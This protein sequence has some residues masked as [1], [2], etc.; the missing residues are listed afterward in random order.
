MRLL[1]SIPYL[2]PMAP[3]SHG[4]RNSPLRAGMNRRANP[5]VPQR[6][7]E[8]LSDWDE[9]V[10]GAPSTQGY[11]SRVLYMKP[12]EKVAAILT[13]SRQHYDINPLSY[14]SLCLAR[15]KRD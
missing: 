4:H 9:R 14:K 8:G 1:W 3:T 11:L 2:S 10:L 5:N 12:R 13:N 15:V 7:S 6:E